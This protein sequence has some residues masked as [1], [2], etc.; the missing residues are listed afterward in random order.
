M[1]ISRHFEKHNSASNKSAYGNFHSPLTLGFHQQVLLR[2]INI[3]GQT[4][5]EPNSLS[6]RCCRWSNHRKAHIGCSSLDATTL[7]PTTSHYSANRAF[8]SQLWKQFHNTADQQRSE[9]CPKLWN[10]EMSWLCYEKKGVHAD[11]MIKKAAIQSMRSKCPPLFG[12]VSHPS[13]IRK[14]CNAANL[15]IYGKIAFEAS[16]CRLYPST[17]PGKVSLT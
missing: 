14:P 8:T 9:M 2:K 6:F 4:N 15:F 17:K 7:T 3:Y 16:T 1:T 11:Q 13:P 5:A 10:I 12:P